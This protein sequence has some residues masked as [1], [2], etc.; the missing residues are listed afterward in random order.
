[1]KLKNEINK[2]IKEF[3]FEFGRM[4][5]R[6]NDILILQYDKD[7]TASNQV[8]IM[9]DICQVKAFKALNV[10]V[11]FLPKEFDL[12]LLSPGSF[13]IQQEIKNGLRLIELE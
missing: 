3:E 12:K 1:M 7:M 11:L 10:Q 9:R 5:L 6:K 13:K 8:R 4:S 2:S